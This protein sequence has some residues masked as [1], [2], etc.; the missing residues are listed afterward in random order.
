MLTPLNA[1]P[2]QSGIKG[3]VACEHV[4]ACCCQLRTIVQNLGCVP[5][6]RYSD[7]PV[8]YV[9]EDVNHGPLSGFIPVCA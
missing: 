3:T 5:V 7:S 4:D 8:W 2:S 9:A 6:Y 1:V